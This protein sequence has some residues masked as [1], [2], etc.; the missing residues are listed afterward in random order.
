[1]S[2]GGAIST[3]VWVLIIIIII[4]VIFVLLKFVIGLFAIVG[5]NDMMVAPV[6]EP[7]K[8]LL[9]S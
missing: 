4:I 5:I 9:P 7:L 1:M 2:A 6:F 3:L 8:L